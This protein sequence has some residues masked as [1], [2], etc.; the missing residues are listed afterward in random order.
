MSVDITVCQV[1]ATCSS[2][3]D[4]AML[5][6]TGERVA[7]PCSG[8]ADDDR[9]STGHPARATRGGRRCRMRSPSHDSRQRPRPQR[10]WQV[11]RATPA[12]PHMLVANP[13]YINIGGAPMHQIPTRRAFP[14]GGRPP[15]TANHSGHT[16]PSGRRRP[17]PRPATR[18]IT[19]PTRP[20]LTPSTSR[21]T[22]DIKG[23]LVGRTE[24]CARRTAGLCSVREAVSHTP[25]LV[26]PFGAAG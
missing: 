6:N 7:P 11:Y 16:P 10:A 1:S 2:S 15:T 12:H 9:P 19:P 18:P 13:A 24:G 14:T 21:F 23:T 26:L 25:R 22:S 20:H 17:P 3:T 5:A 8:S 4:K